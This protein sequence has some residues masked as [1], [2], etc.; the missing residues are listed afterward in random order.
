MKSA[1]PIGCHNTN[2]FLSSQQTHLQGVGVGGYGSQ[3]MVQSR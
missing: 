1:E 2:I 3:R